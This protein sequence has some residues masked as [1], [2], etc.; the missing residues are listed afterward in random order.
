MCTPLMAQRCLLH[1]AASGHRVLPVPRVEAKHRP[2][3]ELTGEEW[4]KLIALGTPK[5]IAEVCS[6]GWSVHTHLPSPS[7]RAHLVIPAERSNT[8]CGRPCHSEHVGCCENNYDPFH[9]CGSK[10]PGWNVHLLGP[11]SGRADI[12]GWSER[13]AALHSCTKKSKTQTQSCKWPLSIL[14]KKNGVEGIWF[15]MRSSRLNFK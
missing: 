6:M 14:K 8:R 3:C 5:I 7:E 13:I 10:F 15:C 1:H 2:S 4:D 12:P 9:F 11:V